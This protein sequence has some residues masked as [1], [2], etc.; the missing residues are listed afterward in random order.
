M[1]ERAV[2]TYCTAPLSVCAEKSRQILGGPGGF[3]RFSKVLVIFGP[4]EAWGL[5]AENFSAD[6]AAG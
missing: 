6:Q 1:G 2:Y 5:E 3:S 4:I